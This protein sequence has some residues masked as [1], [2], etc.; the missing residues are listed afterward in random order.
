MKGKQSEQWFV[1]RLEKLFHLPV[2]IV[3]RPGGSGRKTVIYRIG[4]DLRAVSLRRSAPRAALEARVLERLGPT[5]LSPRLI[6]CDEELVV[7][8]YVTGR[9]L[10]EHLETGDGNLLLGKAARSLLAAQKVASQGGLIG[11]VPK[12]GIRP[13]WE[14]DLA[15]APTRLAQTLGLAEP[16]YDFGDLLK[17]EP[18]Q[19]RTFVKWDARP[20]NAILRENGDVCWIDWEHA[21]ARRAVDDL[22][23]L[24]ADEWA[25]DAPDALNQ[26][27]GPLS[28]EKAGE[29]E[30]T[31]VIFAAAAVA[32]SAMRLSLIVHR[33]GSGPWW[34]RAACLKHDRVGVTAAHVKLVA[35]RAA[36]WAAEVPGLECL[37][38]FFRRLPDALK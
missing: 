19:P 20:G 9:R 13:G 3:A 36:G 37:E 6:L 24:F 32:H 14:D 16:S 38:S 17:L 5:G 33:K 27:L 28:R 10:S 31:T 35:G 1:N 7:Q 11:Q 4:N 22:V 15:A 29:R 12:I 34:D 23:W 2:E 30:K 25:P 26:A 8:E 18:G 21:G